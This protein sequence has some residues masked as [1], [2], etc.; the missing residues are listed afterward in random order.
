M[1]RGVAKSQTQLNN[2]N[3]HKEITRV[4]VQWAEQVGPV[5]PRALSFKEEAEEEP[6]EDEFGE[7]AV[8]GDLK[9]GQ[10]HSGVEAT[11]R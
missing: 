7:S 9:A 4:G 3:D 1:V 2:K 10:L 11:L 6:I 5:E 8:T